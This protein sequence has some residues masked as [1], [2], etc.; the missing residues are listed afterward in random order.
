MSWHEEAVLVICGCRPELDFVIGVTVA[1]SLA[2]LP[3]RKLAIASPPQLP[4]SVDPTGQPS[5]PCSS[6]VKNADGRVGLNVVHLVDPAVKAEFHLVRAVHFVERGRQLPR[7][8]AQ[9]VVAVRIACRC[10]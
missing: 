3:I 6:K 4:E 9:P 8:L 7:V 10:S 5:E 2:I 1:S